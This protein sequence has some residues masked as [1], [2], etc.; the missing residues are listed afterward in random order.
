MSYTKIDGYM[1]RRFIING[2]NLL[3]ENREKIDA[4]NVFPVPDGDTGTNMSMT[5]AAAATAAENISSPNIYEVAKAISGGA[6]RGA[7]GNSGV[8]LSQI[9]RGFAKGLEGK[10]TANCKDLAAAFEQAKETA[11]KAVIKPKEGTILTIVKALADKAA[12][13][14]QSCDSVEQLLDVMLVYAESVLRSTP[15]MLPQLKEAGVV[16]AGGSGLLLI[17]RGGYENLGVDNNLNSTESTSSTPVTA[18][19]A[20]SDAEIKYG[21]CTEFF[22]NLESPN[23]TAEEDL[24]SY[25][26]KIGDSL[27]VVA[28]EDI[29]KIHVHTNNPGLVLERALKT[30]SLDKIKI[31]NMRIQHTNL[32]SFSNKEETKKYGFVSVAS[33]EG[34]ADIFRETGCDKVISGGQTMNP[35][36]EDILKGINSVNA[37]TVYVLPNNKNIILAA[38]QAAEICEGKK[39]YVVESVSMPQGISAMIAFMPDSSPEDNFETMTDAMKC[40]ATGQATYA[41]RNTT[42]DNKEIA[43]GDNLF[44]SEGKIEL[45]GLPL[46]DGLEKLVDKMLEEKDDAGFVCLYCGQDCDITEGENLVAK[47]E[48]KHE[49]VEFE[50]R[51]G[52]QPVYYYIVSVE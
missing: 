51:D 39:V 11:Y 46:Y 29:I 7:R 40:V 6:L 32:I 48:E 18:P 3:M 42:I 25:L 23:P 20:L 14:S 49:D 19:S 10:S 22:I 5:V 36:T 16:D 9:A 24:K 52:G 2:A 30:G 47:L 31:E 50:L 38:K 12:Q 34:M 35:S 33:G 28:D 43:E 15:D 41:V 44:I 4:L 45:T 17:I 21:Y 37:E 1:L 13:A 27:V 8:I 26:T